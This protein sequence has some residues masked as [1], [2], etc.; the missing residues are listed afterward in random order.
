MAKESEQDKYTDPKDPKKKK[1]KS[2]KTEIDFEPTLDEANQNTV[3]FTWGRFNPPTTGHEKLVKKVIAIA[4]QNNATPHIY[5]T[6]SYDPKKNPLPYER[7]IVFAKK[8]FGPVI[9]KSNSKTLFHVLK[10]LEQRGY[11]DIIM[12]VGSDRIKEFETIINKYNGREYDFN[13]VQV[14]SAGDRDPDADDISGMSASKMRAYAINDDLDNF[15]KGVP[16][17]IKRDSKKIFDLIRQNMKI[18][19]MFE[20][21]FGEQDLT[22]EGLFEKVDDILNLMEASE[23]YLIWQKGANVAK[24]ARVIKKGIKDIDV[25][26]KWIKDKGKF[27]DH[28]GKDFVIY[29]YTGNPNSIRPQDIVEDF[30]K[31]DVDNLEKFADRILKKYGIDVEFTRHFV[32]RLNDTRNK[33]EIKIA[34]LQR[35]FKKIQK[36]KGRNIR[37]NPDIEAVLKDMSTNLNLPVVINRKGDSFEVVNKTVMRKSDFKTTSKVIQYEEIDLDEKVLDRMQRIKRGRLMKR[38]ARR[39]VTR[40]KIM[41]KRRAT[42]EKLKNRSRKAA[43]NLLR[44][45]FAGKQGANYKNLT[46]AQKMQIDKRIEKKM[47]SV[48]RLSKRLMPGI[49]KKERDRLS[50]NKKESLDVAFENFLT[51]GVND[52]GI[53]KAIFLAGGPGSGKSFVV[54]KSALGALG[55]VTIASDAFFE[56]ILRKAGMEPNPETISSDKG[57]E[58]RGGAKASTKKKQQLAIRGRLGIVLD[59][60]GKDYNKISKQADRLKELGYEVAMIFVNTD[61]DTSLMRNKMRA[62]TLDEKEVEKMWKDVQKNLG[63]FQSYFKNMFHI[64]DNSDGVDFESE[65]TNTYIRFSKW[66]KTPPRSLKAKEWIRAEKHRVRREQV[67]VSESSDDT[68]INNALNSTPSAQLMKIY[69]KLYKRDY[70]NTSKSELVSKIKSKIKSYKQLYDMISEEGGAGDEGTKKLVK[71]YKK[72]TPNENIG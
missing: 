40:R 31:A 21:F 7:K 50:K 3:V 26:R 45:R 20:T 8:A 1:G 14:V 51:E 65:I 64:V 12:V 66:T 59:G 71:K 56:H 58:M 37:S 9:T 57:Q 34:E 38:L 13:S 70:K 2:K 41:S 39:M 4:K 30:S 18:N 42:P 54:K 55:L 28:G 36:N 44:K 11:S 61:L 68:Q 25:A 33:P 53:F 46:P 32:D 15:T 24:T 17:K 67:E 6:H 47:G 22:E 60:T 23:K 5:L 43:I 72:D 69:K 10:E 49:K 52:P 16:T 19:E 29:K 62:R 63:K 48:E 27:Y 35:F